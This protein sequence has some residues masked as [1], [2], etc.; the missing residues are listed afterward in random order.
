MCWNNPLSP[1]SRFPITSPLLLH[2]TDCLPPSCSHAPHQAPCSYLRP[3]VHDRRADRTSLLPFTRSCRR[4]GL[5]LPTRRRIRL[6]VR[7]WNSAKIYRNPFFLVMQA[8]C[9]LLPQRMC[10]FLKTRVFT[11]NWW[12][13]FTLNICS[14]SYRQQVAGNL[15]NAS[16]MITYWEEVFPCEIMVHKLVV[17]WKIRFMECIIYHRHWNLRI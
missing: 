10:V 7:V 11:H 6:A 13:I 2:C 8:H 9:D 14:R 12:N 3:R 1:P 16:S 15:S 5:R 17:K 4:C